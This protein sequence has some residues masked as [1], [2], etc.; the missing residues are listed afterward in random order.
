MDHYLNALTDKALRRV[1]ADTRY[2]T[3]EHAVAD[4]ILRERGA[5]VTDAV[6]LY[7]Q[8][9]AAAIAVI[10]EKIAALAATRSAHARRSGD[11]FTCDTI[12]A[13]IEAL[14]TAQAVLTD[15]HDGTNDALAHVRHVANT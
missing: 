1:L 4:S 14:E 10:D 11:T 7:D 8:R 9:V 2:S 15:G 3:A 5:T 12:H 6:I 13:A